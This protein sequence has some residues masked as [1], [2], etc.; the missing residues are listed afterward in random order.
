MARNATFAEW[1]GDATELEIS[2]MKEAANKSFWKWLAISLIPIVNIFT[3]GIAIFCY[4]TSSFIKTRGRTNGSN[5]LRFIL[6]CWGGIIPPII[7]V[8]L[9][10]HSDSLGNKVLGFNKIG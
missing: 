10:A 1:A 9:L 7:V 2:Q 3:I 6:M 4:N 8:Q 5:I